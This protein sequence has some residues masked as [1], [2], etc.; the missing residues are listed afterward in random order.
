[1]E[2]K[3]AGRGKLQNW[4]RP[5]VQ[6]DVE[7]A[8]TVTTAPYKRSG[9]P[10]TVQRTSVGDVRCLTAKFIEQGTYRLFTANGETLKVEQPSL[11]TWNIVV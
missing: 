4:T 1:M 3:L 10:T 11:G 8:F 6:F 9:F 5:S 7:Y 2:E